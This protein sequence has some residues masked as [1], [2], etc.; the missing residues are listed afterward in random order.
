[1]VKFF[2][3]IFKSFI[4]HT[5]LFIY[6][7][8]RSCR[9]IYKNI[10]MSYSNSNKKTYIELFKILGNYDENRKQTRIVNVDEFVEEYS[11][12]KCGNG[13][14]WCRFDREFG[15][16]YKSITIK[17]NG[18][19]R[20]SWN[21]NEEEDVDIKNIIN[22]YMHT[23]NYK[24]YPGSNIQYLF[25]YG[26]QS[27]NHSRPIRSDIREI[28]KRLPCV[29]CGTTHGIE[30]DHKNGLYND[31]RVLNIETQNVDDFQPLC[32]HC[33]CQKRQT[34]AEMKKTGIRYPATRIPAIGQFDIDYIKGNSNFDL[35][36]PNTMIGTY[37][38]DPI[39]F[40]KHIKINHNSG[41]SDSCSL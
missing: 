32:K 31:P 24:Y 11:V 3:M 41:N 5:P 8:L 4:L 18:K 28:L 30:I 39:A 23:N 10:C 13:A 12:L 36:D 38:Y 35:N 15:K 6:G 20:T 25:I 1:M 21:T 34:Y 14:D 19:M 33:N 17:R 16:K 2:H 22:E 27:I 37:W 29:H 7:N 26:E 40:L 9:P